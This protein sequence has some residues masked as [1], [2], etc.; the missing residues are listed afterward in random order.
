MVKDVNFKEDKN[1]IKDDNGAVNMVIFNTILLNY[2]RQ[3]INDSIK[4]V[5]IL[6]GQN[7]KEFF[8][9][10]KTQQTCALK[11]YLCWR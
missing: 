2:H 7:V 9:K 8:F 3:N 4:K 11:D 6:F 1:K 5:Q 10:I